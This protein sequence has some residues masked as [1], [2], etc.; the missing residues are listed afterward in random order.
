MEQYINNVVDIL[1]E[2]K[3]F[4]FPVLNAHGVL[5]EAHLRS[6]VLTWL[7]QFEESERGTLIRLTSNLL[8]KRFIKENKEQEFISNVLNTNPI[9]VAANVALPL[10]VQQDGES[11]RVMAEFYS[12]LVDRYGYNYDDSKFVYLDDFMFSGRR[13]FSDLSVFITSLRQS[14]T[15]Y[16]A[17][18]GWHNYGQWYYRELLQQKINAHNREF[19][20]K[21]KVEWF[22]S[23]SDSLLENRK[24]YNYKSDILWPMEDTFNSEDLLPFKIHN[25]NYRNGFEANSTFDNNTDRMFLE[26]ICLKYGY[27][28]MDRCNRVNPTTKPLGNSLFDYGFGG[29]VFNYRNCPNNTPLI[30]WWG[31]ND[32]NNTIMYNQWY[33]LMPR[34]TY[35]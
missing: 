35:G 19:N 26:R 9:R 27:K 8:T 13:V 23:C 18:L 24:T 5:E 3:G 28:I 21:V 12:Q 22:Y 1:K 6:H 14:V 25:Y 2:Y 32:P 16:V 10:S 7:N 33:P 20:L 29:L 34:R 31:S 11:Q 15:I 17:I 4:Y 30:F